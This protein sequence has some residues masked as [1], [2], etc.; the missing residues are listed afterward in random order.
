MPEVL[1]SPAVHDCTS[2]VAVCILSLRHP[3]KPVLLHIMPCSSPLFYPYRA[4]PHPG[5][6]SIHRRS[7]PYSVRR[8]KTL[9]PSSSS[10]AQAGAVSPQFLSSSSVRRPEALGVCGSPARVTAG[11]PAPSPSS[12]RRS[13]ARV[14]T[15]P[16]APSSSSFR[17]PEGLTACGSPPRV[18]AGPQDPSPASVRRSDARISA[19][20]RARSPASFRKPETLPASGSSSRV[21]AGPQAPSPSSA[22]RPDARVTTGPQAPSPSSFIKPEG[23][24]ACPGSSPV[25]VSAG[26]RTPSPSGS[27][28]PRCLSACG[29]PARLSA[30]S[31]NSAS[32]NNRRGH[33]ARAS[34]PVAKKMDLRDDSDSESTVAAVAAAIEAAAAAAVAA[35]V[36]KGS[37]ASSSA[38]AVGEPSLHRSSRASSGNDFPPLIDA[39]MMDKEAGGLASQR[40]VREGGKEGSGSPKSSTRP[41]S[42]RKSFQTKGE[43]GPLAGVG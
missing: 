34:R 39:L 8:S 36:T 23:L 35:P 12:A 32:P 29:S 25:G 37:L 14:T 22:R 11:P 19:A 13:D 43:W 15:G 4:A 10:P 2:V 18:S 7:S 6:P 24:T 40:V 42:T 20:P 9:G 1:Q 31:Q 16:Q 27:R 38:A 33:T 41:G 21:S 30:G 3:P 17:Q 26:P 5:F 28:T